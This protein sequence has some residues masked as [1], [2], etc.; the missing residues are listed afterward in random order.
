MNEEYC[1]VL[2]TFESNEQAE[3]CVDII[4]ERKLA[5][6]VQMIP[7]RSRYFWDNSVQQDNE[8]LVLL[9][10]RGSLY[11]ALKKTLEK[12]HPYDTPE[13]LRISVV[14]GAKPYLEWIN[15]VTVLEGTKDE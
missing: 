9:K 2:T 4:I 7:I 14:D 10:T 11:D 15:D 13:I 1:I 8:I 12:I 3:K 5:A 6:C